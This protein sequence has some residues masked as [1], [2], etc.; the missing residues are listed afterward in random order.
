[1]AFCL[2]ALQV[3]VLVRHP[4]TKEL[5]VN[6]DPAVHTVVRESEWM[7]KLG[8]EIPDSAGIMTYL[9]NSL[10]NNFDQLSV[11]I[12]FTVHF[13]EFSYRLFWK[14]PED[15]FTLHLLATCGREQGNHRYNSGRIQATHAAKNWQGECRHPPRPDLLDMDFNESGTLLRPSQTRA[16]RARKTHKTGLCVFLQWMFIWIH[17]YRRDWYILR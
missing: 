16:Y 1:M 4:S 5:Y 10:K 13:N 9:R 8:L 6:L 2:A 17:R 15:F 7:R 12:S 3:P 11:R 14:I